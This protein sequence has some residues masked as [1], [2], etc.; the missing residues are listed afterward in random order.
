LLDCDSL[1]AN[2]KYLMNAET[3]PYREFEKALADVLIEEQFGIDRHSRLARARV[4]VDPR[5]FRYNEIVTRLS[6]F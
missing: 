5:S 3:D 1:L 4:A 2:R 6:N